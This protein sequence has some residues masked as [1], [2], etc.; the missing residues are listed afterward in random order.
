[1]ASSGIMS[2][3]DIEESVLADV[4]KFCNTPV[5]AIEDLYECTPSQIHMIHETKPEVYQFVLTFGPGASIERFSEALQGVISKNPTLRTRFAKCHLGTLQVVLGVEEIPIRPSGDVDQYLRG[6]RADGLWLGVPLFR[7]AFL[8]RNFVATIHH[9]V[10]DY[11]SWFTMFN[12][13]VAA[14]YY[15]HATPERPAF[16]E[17]VAHCRAIDD[18]EAKSFWASR[19][20]GIPAAFP[21]FKSGC[22][23]KVRRAMTREVAFRRMSGEEVHAQMPYYI[24]AAWAITSSIYTGNDSVSYG[25]LLSGR[26]SS[27]NGFQGT[28]G[29]T[30]TEVP[31]QVDLHRNMTVGQ[32]IK[33]R[34]L[35]LRQLQAHPAVH[36]GISKINAASQASKHAASY[37]TLLNIL[38][39]LPAAGGNTDI[40][41]DRMVSV[42]APFPLHLI[43]S[44]NDGGFII[45]PR[46]DPEAISEVQ[47]NQVL[48]QFEYVLQLLTEAAPKTK[49]SSLKLLNPHDRQRISTWNARVVEKSAKPIH[50]LFR[51]QVRVRPD[52]TAVEASDGTADYRLLD[53]MTD[54]LAQELRRRGVV[55]SVAVALVFERSLWAVVAML[56]ILKAGGIC[57]PLDKND[58]IEDRAAIC[59]RV[60]VKLVLTSSTEYS[61]SVGLAV[62]IFSVGADSVSSILD[63]PSAVVS[64]MSS[65]ADIA[66]IL[67]T[68]GNGGESQGMV[69]QHRS[70]VSSLKSQA[71]ALSWQPGSRLLH[72]APYVSSWSVYEVLGM[73]LSGGCLCVSTDSDLEHSLSRAIQV[74]QPNWAILP[75]GELGKLLP[76]NAPSLQSIVCTG[77]PLQSKVMTTWNHAARLFRGWGACEASLLSTLSGVNSASLD[78]DCV[79]FPIGCSVWIVNPQNIHDLAPIG[80]T[81]ELLIGGSGVAQ[82]YFGDGL[83]TAASFIAPPQWASLFAAGSSKF[84]RTGDLGR[85]NPDGSIVLVGRRSSRVKIKGRTVQLEELER[86]LLGCDELSHVVMLT[87]ISAGRTVVV[88]VVC[89]SDA[90]LPTTRTLQRLPRPHKQIVDRSLA[91]VEEYAQAA[92]PSEAVPT[93]WIAVEWLPWGNTRNVDRDRIRRWLNTSKNL[94]SSADLSTT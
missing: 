65:P 73:L 59:S 54:R 53:Q 33:N 39:E 24:E 40:K 86:K 13:D 70:L 15:G 76:G 7:A 77:E 88:A 1:M 3:A 34:A 16:K 57:V 12:V 25:Y 94:L 50:E 44:I 84:Y 42:E 18:S 2:R 23:D 14:A 61:K 67:F 75:S 38:P 58:N 17:F 30:V 66:Y 28:L 22:S 52:A 81:G 79:G 37:R 36:W 26:S 19:F 64:N 29:P 74:T 20:R 4:A 69:F 89:L 87:Q 85:Y 90:R 31:V 47:L 55:R 43:F 80:S 63:A 62:D 21:S 71:Q 10:M 8:G 60:G 45:D 32:L 49:L 48:N 41:L 72:M 92:L 91:V 35:S 78:V 51:D 68:S 83:K 46:F 56:G 9:A 11:W 5:T 82:G 27:S 93:I 6:S